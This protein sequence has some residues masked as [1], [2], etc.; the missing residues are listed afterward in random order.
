M[1]VRYLLKL[2]GNIRHGQIISNNVK[3]LSTNGLQIEDRLYRD[4]FWWLNA[5]RSG[6]GRATWESLLI[7]A[8]PLGEQWCPKVCLGDLPLAKGCPAKQIAK[9]LNKIEKNDVQES[10]AEKLSFQIGF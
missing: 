8:G 2:K 3:L 9:N 4:S 1:S 10:V 7:F 5:P 6:S